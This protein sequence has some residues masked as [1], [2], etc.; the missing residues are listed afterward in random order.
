MFE[1]TPRESTFCVV[2]ERGNAEDNQAVSSI[3][4]RTSYRLALFGLLSATTH[5]HYLNALEQYP[6][7]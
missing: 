5:E 3:K 7:R 4:P 2:S 6:N 1:S